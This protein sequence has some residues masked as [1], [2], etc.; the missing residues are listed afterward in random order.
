MNKTAL[1]ME[2]EELLSLFS[3]NFEFKGTDGVNW[4]MQR[5]LGAMDS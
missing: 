2:L 5:A 4:I 3:Q 1:P